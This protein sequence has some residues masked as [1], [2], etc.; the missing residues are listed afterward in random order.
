MNGDEPKPESTLA[1]IFGASTWPKYPAFQDLPGS[2]ASAEALRDYL[3]DEKGFGL[4]DENLRYLFD[5]HE[6]SPGILADMSRF[7]RERTKELRERGQPAQ[8]IIVFYVGH[9]GF[10]DSTSDYFLAIRATQGPDP[11]LSSIPVRSLAKAL[12]DDTRHLRRYII[13][14]SCFSG[15]AY[16]SFQST[17]VEIAVTKTNDSFPSSG[18]GILCSSGARDPS[19]APPELTHT[20]FSGA[21]LEFLRNGDAEALFDRQSS[22]QPRVSPRSRLC[23]RLRPLDAPRRF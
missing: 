3:L 4:P 11:Y 12:K 6:G 22:P 2:K 15:A 23:K 1:I 13:L 20:M 9:G 21:L 18:T 5:A 19:K 16:T 17:P 7:L 10:A 8:D 14:D